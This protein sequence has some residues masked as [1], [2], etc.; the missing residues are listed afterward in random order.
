MNVP[1]LFGFDAQPPT[2]LLA[3]A[4][5]CAAGGAAA[6]GSA[7]DVERGRQLFMSVGCY[8]CH[9]TVGQGGERSAGPRIAP[10]PMPL[11]ALKVFV[12]N[13][14][15][16]MPRFDAR[17]LSDGQVEDIHRYLS[18]IPKGRSAK[19]IPLLQQPKG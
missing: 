14:P 12:R 16:G 1:N 5:G 6:Q 13:P 4:L 8:S 17:F 18:S 2:L 10:D 9:G 3:L 7:A 11:E 15:E 19:D